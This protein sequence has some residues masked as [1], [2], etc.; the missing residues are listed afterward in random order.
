MQRAPKRTE[1]CFRHGIKKVIVIFVLSYT[2]AKYKLGIARDISYEFRL[3][4]LSLHLTILSFFLFLPWNKKKE[5]ILTFLGIVS[6]Q[7]WSG[8]AWYFPGLYHTSEHLSDF[9]TS[10]SSIQPRLTLSQSLWLINIHLWPNKFWHWTVASLSLWFG[11]L[12]FWSNVNASWHQCAWRWGQVSIHLL[13]REL[14]VAFTRF[15]DPDPL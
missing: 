6:S 11:I 7:L 3:F 1:T 13:I 12:V 8:S 4:F 2:S 9:N 5:V 15:F 14:W 10:T